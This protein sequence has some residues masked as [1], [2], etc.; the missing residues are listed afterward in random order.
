MHAEGEIA[1]VESHTQC[2]GGDQRLE[3]V[4]AQASFE[5]ESQISIDLTGVRTD[6]M[7]LG[8]QPI[9]SLVRLGDCE[10]VDDARAI[11]L[12]QRLG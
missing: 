6:V 5:F 7:A 11:E 3:L 4:V 9:G 10:G 12:G 2:T 8:S 1:F